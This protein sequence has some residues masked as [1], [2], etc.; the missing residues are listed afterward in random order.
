MH[1]QVER[2]QDDVVGKEVHSLGPALD[3]RMAPTVQ[4]GEE[5]G[6]EGVDPLCACTLLLLTATHQQVQVEVDH[7]RR[8]EREREKRKKE[9]ARV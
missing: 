7:L 1:S 4:L 5:E 8:E 3:G 2:H 6:V 9:T